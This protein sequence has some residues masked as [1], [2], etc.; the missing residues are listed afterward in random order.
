MQELY[1]RDWAKYSRSDELK[2]AM[3]QLDATAQRTNVPIIM[4]AQLKRET[5]SPLDLYNQ[6][7]ADSA[8]VERKASEIVLIW[9]N[10]ERA[11]GDGAEKTYKR[12]S[13]EI[14]KDLGET[15]NLGTEGKLYLRLTKSR[16]IPTGSHSIIPISGSTGRVGDKNKRSEPK[17]K[18]LFAN[19]GSPLSDYM[20]T[21]YDD[22]AT[23]DPESQRPQRRDREDDGDGLPF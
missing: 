18:E 4:A 11:K 7:I 14:E 3:V 5:N 12:I 10:K 21:Y 19:G 2:E 22:N 6:F 17:Q 9:S 1:V 15:L 8:W 20:R 13:E 23:I 16:I